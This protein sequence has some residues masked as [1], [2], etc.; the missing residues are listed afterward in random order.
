[1]RRRAILLVSAAGM[2]VVLAWKVA[3]MIVDGLVGPSS[4]VLILASGLLAA[5][6]VLSNR[7]RGS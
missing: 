1:M 3:S 4:I 2:A 5:I 6:V 7:K